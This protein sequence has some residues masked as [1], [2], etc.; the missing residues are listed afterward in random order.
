M[1]NRQNI[2]IVLSLIVFVLIM[3][4]PEPDGMNPKAMKAAGVSI[5]MAILWVTEAISIFAT[6]FIP[7]VFFPLLGILNADH[8]AASYGHHI[9][10]LIIGAFLV[11]K[12]IETNNLHKRIALGTIQLI[13]TSR[14]QIILSFMFASAFLSM[15]TS[16]NSTTL[17]MLPI[18]LAVIQRETLSKKDT[19]GSALVLSIAY[20]AS[21]GGTGTL[22][23]TPPNLLFVSTL[24]GIFPD[25]PDIVFTDWLKIGLPFV[26]LFLPIAWVFIITY[27]NVDGGLSGS[28][29]IIE[30]EYQELGTM[31]TAEKRVLIICIFYALGFVFR[32]KM[33]IS[34]LTIMGWSDYLGVQSY[35]KDSTVAFFA[36][37]LLFLIPN[38]KINKDGTKLKLLEWEDAKTV[39]WGIAMLIG[40]GLAIASAFKE[41]QLILWI[42]QNLNLDGISIFLVILLVVGGM[43]FLTEINSNT[44]STA[45]FLP[46]L[47]GLSQ[48]GNFHPFLLMIPATIAASCAFMLPSGTG[49]NAIVLS[50][51]HVSIPV[52]AKCGFWLNLIAIGVIVILLYFVILP[53]LG[54]GASIPDWM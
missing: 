15:W 54:V 24:K 28:N 22:I 2:G 52:M 21:I 17:M 42:G 11:A 4:L 40:G 47:A 38:G 34:F 27:F 41:S 51:G 10:L 50:S 23:G 20:A 37:L 7:I 3:I 45:I 1:Y 32:Q 44:A 6:A 36:A 48:A 19:F 31:S 26:V 18:G 25:S 43:V 35:V 39:P 13:G 14:R 46:V 49:P 9:V 5:L 53:F 29:E 12:A 33:D 8:I 16:N 30:K